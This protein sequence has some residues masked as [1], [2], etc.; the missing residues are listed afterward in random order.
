MK[1][2]YTFW[3]TLLSALLTLALAG[4]R[5]IVESSTLTQVPSSYELTVIAPPMSA[6]TVT[7]SP[8]GINC[9]TTCTASF[10][11]NTHVTLTAT[12]GSNYFFG[13]WSGGC[14]GTG[15]CSLTITATVSVTASFN[16]GY[17]LTVTMAGAGTG[18]VTSS[19]AGINCPTTCS[20]SFAPDSQVT[21]SET[22]GTNNAFAGWSGACTGAATCSVNVTA[23][24]SV[25]ATFSSTPPSY[26][27]TMTEA[28]TGTGTV[29]SVPAGIK[30]PTICSASFM[31]NT[32]V[33][34]SETP[35]VNSIFAG[36]SGACTGTATCS[37]NVTAADSVTATF[38]PT[39]PSYTVTVAEA[40]TGTGTVTSAPAGINCPTTCSASFTQNAQV[41]LSET[42]GANSIFA[43]WSGACTGTATCSVTVTAAD[44]VTATFSP[45][46]P[47]YLVTVIEAGTGT[48]T[49]TSIPV[50]INCPTTCSAGFTQNTQV[51]LSE[52][53]GAN[54][55]FAGW[56]GACTGTATCSVTVTAADSVTATFS[57]GNI[58]AALN[59]II[60]FAQENRSLD[61]Y[62]GAML[63]YWS[64]NGYGTGGQTF[65]G[66][67]QFNP[68]VNGI[69][70]AP[71][72]LPG[73]D[74]TA[75]DGQCTAPSANY[76]VT[77]FHFASVCQEEESP[78]WNEAH[79]DWDYTD[80]ADQPAENPPPLNGFVF[81]AA[82]DAES[83]LLMDVNGVRAMGY[84][85]WTDLNYY[86]FM[87]SNFGTSDTWFAPVMDRTQINRM[88]MLAATSQG[89]AYPIGQGNNNGAQLT[90]TTIFEA[91]QNAG[92][93]WKIYVNSED[94]VNQK[95][96]AACNNDLSDEN[97]ECLIQS[98]YINMFTY[99]NTIINSAGQNPDLLQNIVPVTQF[100]VDAA[101]GTLP[102]FALIEPASAASL[103]EHP[104]DLDTSNPADVQAGANY[105]AGLIGELMASPNWTD[106][107]MIFTYDEGGG[108]YDHVPPQPATPPG[109]YLS[110]F[111]LVPND[112]C[113]KAGQELGQGTC[114]FAWTG[115]RIPLIV[116][117]P[118]SVKNFVSHNV[119]D[120]TAVLK[121]VETRFGLPPLTARDGSQMDMA[122][123]FDFVNKPWATPPTPPTQVQD[124][125]CSLV[126]P[127][128]WN[129][130]PTL[131]A[132]ISGATGSGSVA[133][134]PGN[135]TACK[136]GGDG[137]FGSFTYGTD[138][139]L[140]ATPSSGYTFAGWSGAGCSGTATC[141]VTVT[142]N[143]SVTATFTPNT[144]APAGISGV[145]H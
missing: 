50:G 122:E 85:D 134:S 104:N 121:M 112:I 133:G 58:Y 120:T 42:P 145:T 38:S 101:N 136:P 25:T 77:S 15:T 80:Q 84:F 65:N 95:N 111:D 119:R 33:T 90:A 44:S 17:A 94:A 91:L 83:N 28:G 31:Q 138:V 68:P 5:G 52:T 93:S 99:E 10:A 20:A 48:G 124:G 96:G 76:P 126:P 59:H 109:D 100:A 117:S 34:L 11:E 22:P 30:C 103:D 56:S 57:P 118:Y 110:P 1:S 71:P 32:Q 45:T 108:F 106:S 46:P 78:F 73:C 107:A 92:I 24:D 72:T 53:P 26:I 132:I 131:V 89:H 16:S 142:A 8:A 113:D 64:A 27:V 105:A 61:H 123:F 125:Q 3:S 79:N 88:Y 23:A 49:V 35:G 114:D 141:S 21:L 13:G 102:Q 37:V 9:P 4:C 66:L 115:Y 39:S 116:I 12:A 2:R 6:G 140:T 14:S 130:P 18:T 98:A 36:W 87:A 74:V 137:C 128:S 62:F 143:T 51:T 54:S 97:A 70:P 60:L 86:Y 129:D 139:T 144:P 43:G 63:G 19:P 7:S 75:T 55:I 135:I 41:T 69:P 81:T 67:P 40:G 47:S 82:Y 29:T 127:A